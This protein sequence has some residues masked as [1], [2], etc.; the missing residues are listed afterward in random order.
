[1]RDY[2]HVVDL[3]EGHVAALNCLNR[4]GGLLTV[5][6][7]TVQGHTALDLVKAFAQATGR[8][9]AYKIATRRAGDIAQC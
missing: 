8:A 6:L 9:I 2:L 1:M 4:E 7:G 3:A 5:N